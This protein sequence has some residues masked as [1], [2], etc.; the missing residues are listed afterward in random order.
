MIGGEK[1]DLRGLTVALMKSMLSSVVPP[2]PSGCSVVPGAALNRSMTALES[3]STP[4]TLIGAVISLNCR[5]VPCP[6]S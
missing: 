4:Y 1:V 6:K 3:L 2:C 5:C